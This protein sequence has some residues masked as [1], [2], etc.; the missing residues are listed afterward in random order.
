[1]HPLMRGDHSAAQALT[2]EPPASWRKPGLHL[3]QRQLGW[4]DAQLRPQVARWELAPRA[5]RATVELQAP[6]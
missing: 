4:Q 6:V 3:R 5:A 1:M 2:V